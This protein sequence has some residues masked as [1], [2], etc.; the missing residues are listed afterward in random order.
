[1]NPNKS[2]ETRQ[3]DFWSW[4]YDRRG[5]FSVKSVYCMITEIKQRWE[6]YLERRTDLQIIWT[7]SGVRGICGV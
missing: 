5:L 3:A 6:D 2:C 1:V 4:H 7:M